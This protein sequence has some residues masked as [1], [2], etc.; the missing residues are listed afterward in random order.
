MKFSIKNNDKRDKLIKKE[1]EYEFGK[2][3]KK[4]FSK[5]YNRFNNIL[6]NCVSNNSFKNVRNTI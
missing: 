1:F 5:R 3:K 4:I 6:I 2:D